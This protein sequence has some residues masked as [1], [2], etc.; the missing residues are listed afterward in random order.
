MV[1]TTAT[2]DTIRHELLDAVEHLLASLRRDAEILADLQAVRDLLDSLP[3]ATDEYHT[4]KNRLRNA[5]RYLVSH[6]RGA[7]RYELKLL[8]GSLR[9]GETHPV[10]PHLRL[11]RQPRT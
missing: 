1:L 4:A 6:E 9:P 5:H 8:A 7:A 2:P 11:R 3:L 10:G